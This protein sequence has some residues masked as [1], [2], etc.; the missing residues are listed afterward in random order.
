M[1]MKTTLANSQKS[2]CIEH[3]QDY[4]DKRSQLAHNDVS[5]FFAPAWCTNWENSLLWLAGC[6]PSQYIRLVY[7][8]CGLEIEVHLSEFLQGTSSS[9]ANLGYLSS[10]QLHPINMLQGKTLRSEEKLTNRMATLQED[11]ADH[12]IVGIAKGLSQVGEM[13]GEVDRALDKHEQAMVG[14]LEEA[15]RLRLNTL[16]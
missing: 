7:A 15:G 14:V 5:A 3:F 16:K 4:A 8:L 11:V 1:K 13:N 10:K 12:P 2:A 6:R 9:S